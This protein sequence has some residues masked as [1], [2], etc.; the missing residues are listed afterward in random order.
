MVV[1]LKF[2]FPWPAKGLICGRHLHSS[3]IFKHKSDN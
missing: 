3:E 1:E 2:L